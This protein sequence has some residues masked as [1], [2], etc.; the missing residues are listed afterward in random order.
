MTSIIYIE[1]Q[2]AEEP[3]T[4]RICERYPR[5]T[6]ILCRHYGEIFN[7]KG[8][9]FRLQKQQPALILARKQR[10]L[11]LAAPP[12]YGLG[13]DRHYYFSHMLNC[14][15]DCRYCF[16]QGMYRS[17]HYVIFVNH[18]DFKQAISDT[19]RQSDG[20]R[21]WFYSGYDCDS[22][23]FDPVT[24]FVDSFIPFF[25]Q[26][27][28]AWLELRSKS[29]HTRAL[30]QQQ[31]LDNAVI[32]FSFTPDNISQALEHGVP[33][34]SRRLQAI[35]RLH[36]HGWKI[37]LRFDPLIYCDDFRH[38]YRALFREVFTIL[39]AD[40]LHSVSLGSF[41]LPKPFFNTMQRLYPDEPLLAGPLHEQQGMVGYRNTLASDLTGFC[42][43]ELLRYIPESIFFP[44][45]DQGYDQ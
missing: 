27:P 41:R 31:P 26:L 6:R 29:P 35:L 39:P 24:G 32:A 42:S 45:F 30:L 28:Q 10:Q 40:C 44:C 8:Q 15:Y 36:Q 33:S 3:L 5:A 17:A 7:R 43:E 19:L 20:Q 34:L 14:V 22:L 18:E 13:G 11:V 2:A 4:Q 12:G 9:N 23:A 37:G 16:L 38:H 21:T 1:E 25:R